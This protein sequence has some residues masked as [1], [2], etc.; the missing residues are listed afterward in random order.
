MSAYRPVEATPPVCNPSDV[1]RTAEQCRLPGDHSES[2]T[3]LVPLMGDVA[4]RRGC[5]AEQV[6]MT[7]RPP[8]AEI[9][10]ALLSE[11]TVHVVPISSVAQL[12]G[13][14]RIDRFVP[15]RSA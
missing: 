11:E 12:R 5:E 2:P 1:W 6:E 3:L 10:Q 9:S 14:G 13:V 15:V 7:T 8:I 4:A